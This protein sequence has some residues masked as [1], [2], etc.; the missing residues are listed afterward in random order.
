MARH[1]T[2]NSRLGYTCEADSPSTDEYKVGGTHLEPVT[3]EAEMGGW[4]V[5]DQLK[6][7]HKLPLHHK[8]NTSLAYKARSRLANTGRRWNQRGDTEKCHS[9]R[10]IILT[11]IQ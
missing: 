9:H 1:R 10:I 11:H 3:L 8:F 4:R 6:Q 7:F 2:E 5:Q